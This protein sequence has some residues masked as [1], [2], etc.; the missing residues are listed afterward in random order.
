LTS[1]VSADACIGATG[2]ADTVAALATVIPSAAIATIMMRFIV[3]SLRAALCDIDTISRSTL[4]S[5]LLGD[6]SCD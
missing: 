1:I 6:P 5:A 2:M 4:G 3:F